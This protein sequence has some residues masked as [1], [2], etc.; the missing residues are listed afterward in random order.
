MDD[1]VAGKT[2]DDV[3]VPLP[4]REPGPSR[5]VEA[6]QRLFG[7]APGPG[8]DGAS[9]LTDVERRE[10]S[11]ALARSATARRQAPAAEE[12]PADTDDGR[13]AEETPPEPPAQ[14]PAPEQGEPATRPPRRR[15]P[16]PL[17]AAVILAF[18]AGIVVG[19]VVA[20]SD[21]A[22]VAAT[23]A[24]S[25]PVLSGDV[26][27]VIDA[28]RVTVLVDD[29]PVEVAVLGLDPPRAEPNGL[30]MVHRRLDLAVGPGAHRPK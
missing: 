2:D 26:V 30:I 23:P 25:R 7:D 16:V 22:A 9:R 6:H 10:R 21:D 11:A 3:S 19:L 1:G 17:V 24:P 5:I 20:P 29:R 12:Q 4:R 15:V 28:G 8:T 14:R 27:R 18:V 13:E